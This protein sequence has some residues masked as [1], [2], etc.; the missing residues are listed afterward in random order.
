MY[1]ILLQHPFL[2]YSSGVQL[3][4]GFLYGQREHL[5]VTELNNKHFTRQI[6]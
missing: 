5:F 6:F 1:G 3:M 2:C 4:M